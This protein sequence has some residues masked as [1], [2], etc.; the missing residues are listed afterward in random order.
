MKPGDDRRRRGRLAGAAVTLR[1]RPDEYRFALLFERGERRVGIGQ[2]RDAPAIALASARHAGTAE[3]GQLERGEVVQRRLGGASSDL[4]VVD[5][6]PE[7]LILERR[8]AR[9]QLVSAPGVRPASDEDVAIGS[10]QRDVVDG[11][12]G[13]PD[14]HECFGGRL[15]GRGVDE[16][17]VGRQRQVIRIRPFL[18]RVVKSEAL[19]PWM[20]KSSASIGR[21]SGSSAFG[22]NCRRNWSDWYRAS[23]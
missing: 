20:R 4:G 22:S 21:N 9:V 6:G 17:D 5:E 7:R 23:T 1:A 18:R 10:R 19:A 2:R 16:L 12:N 14:I 15:V 11:G 3:Q 8:D 13:A